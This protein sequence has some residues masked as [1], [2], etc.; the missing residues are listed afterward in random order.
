VGGQRGGFVVGARLRFYLAGGE[1]HYRLLNPNGS[2]TLD[3]P[4]P[5][6]TL[7]V[8]DLT[9]FYPADWSAD[10][11]KSSGAIDLWPPES[12]TPGMSFI[13]VEPLGP[14]GDLDAR[15]VA[16]LAEIATYLNS[17]LIAERALRRGEGFELQYRWID[18]PGQTPSFHNWER[19]GCRSGRL[20][21]VRLNSVDGEFERL[22]G[23]AWAVMEGL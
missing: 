16:L 23:V 10:D 8:G 3:R 17:E 4:P 12:S 20:Y 21:R 6:Q 1:G 9:V 22:R 11:P 18:A 19:Y 2:E 15:R 14:C 7:K 13:A 5:F